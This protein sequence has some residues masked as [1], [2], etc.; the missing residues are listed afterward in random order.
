MK[1]TDL[2]QDFYIQG[3]PQEKH[4]SGYKTLDIKQMEQCIRIC[5]L[6]LRVWS[7]VNNCESFSIK[8][9]NL[10]SPNCDWSIHVS[11]FLL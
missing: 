1:I 4:L 10:H 9:Y 8:I 7:S 6:T 11:I 5:Y 2:L 3:Y